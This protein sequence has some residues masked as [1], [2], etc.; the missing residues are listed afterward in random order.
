MD[1][2]TGVNEWFNLKLGW[3]RSTCIPMAPFR[4]AL[5]TYPT[6]KHYVASDEDASDTLT[7]E[8][9]VLPL[10]NASLHSIAFIMSGSP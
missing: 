8:L 4:R 10:P 9:R 1:V 3:I 5:K 2:V 6:L 7:T